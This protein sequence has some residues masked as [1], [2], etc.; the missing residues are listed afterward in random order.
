MFL[1]AHPALLSSLSSFIT[2]IVPIFIARIHN[3]SLF[4]G[5]STGLQIHNCSYGL[6]TIDSNQK[7]GIRHMFSLFL[8]HLVFY[9]IPDFTI[10][11]VK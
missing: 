6:L 3:P 5:S 10:S 8:P 11:Y 9:H 1:D 2:D 7:Q 4:P